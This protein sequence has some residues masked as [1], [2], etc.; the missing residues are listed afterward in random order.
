MGRP[1]S[2]GA[3]VAYALL[4]LCAKIPRTLVFLD[5][6]V[7]EGPQNWFAERTI[8]NHAAPRRRGQH[9]A[10]GHPVQDSPAH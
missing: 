4:G 7:E 2:E 6:V 9:R 3:K 8:R 1:P 5:L 10:G